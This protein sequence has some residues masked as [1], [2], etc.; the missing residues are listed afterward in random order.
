MISIPFL[1]HHHN[2]TIALFSFSIWI[3]QIFYFLFLL[4]ISQWYTYNTSL[5]IFYHIHDLIITLRSK[6]IN[7]LFCVIFK[8]N[9]IVFSV[10]SKM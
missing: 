1:L 2:Y 6:I 5:S 4:L 3:I 8:M 7:T 9:V 10:A